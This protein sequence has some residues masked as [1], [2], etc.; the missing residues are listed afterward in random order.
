MID[1][2]HIF[3]IVFH[4]YRTSYQ[5]SCSVFLRS[6]MRVVS[7]GLC[8][9][10]TTAT[11]FFPLSFH[12]DIESSVPFMHT[13]KSPTFIFLSDFNRFLGKN[14]RV[15]RIVV[16]E[17]NFLSERDLASPELISILRPEVSSII[18]FHK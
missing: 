16:Q 8:I 7:Q 9:V 18:F 17:K 12:F 11:D 15:C 1:T 5:R 2:S 3:V 14:L 6:W 4:R 13:S 10:L